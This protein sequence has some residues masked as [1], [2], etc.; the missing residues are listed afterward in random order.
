MET[1]AKRAR[2]RPS[3]S[4]D[5][6]LTQPL[7]DARDDDDNDEHGR[8]PEIE[9]CPEDNQNV[10]SAAFFGWL[11]PMLVKGSKKPLEYHDMPVTSR[12]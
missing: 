2:P 3:W 12:S 5:D 7:L 1:E 9:R 6:T 4:N 11:S 8:Q 10:F